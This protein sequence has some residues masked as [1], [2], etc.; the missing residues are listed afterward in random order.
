MERLII[1]V[2]GSPA[3]NAFWES[4][5][6]CRA[7]VGGIGAGKT[8]AL[9]VDILRQPA[10]SRGMIV[11]PT[12]PMLRDSTLA[13][14]RDKLWSAVREWSESDYEMTLWNG[15]KVL[16]RSADDPERLRGPNLGWAAMD[17]AALQPNRLAFDIL[18][19]RLREPPGRISLAT[20]PRGYNWIWQ[21]FIKNKLPG[22]ELFTARTRDNPHLPLEYIE[23]LEQAYMGF[24]ARQELEGQFVEWA[25]SP[26]YP[27]FSRAKNVRNGLAKLYRREAP[28]IVACDFNVRYMCWPIAQVYRGVPIVIAEIV[29][30]RPAQ[31]EQM[32]RMFRDLFPA[33]PGGVWVY[34]D[35]SGKAEST[36]S[37]QSDYDI[38]MSEMRTYPS[39]VQLRVPL[40]NPSPKDRINAVN[41]LM[42]G[43]DG[44]ARLLIDEG[45]EE[46]IIDITQTEWDKSGR[47]EKQYSDE[48]DPRS[49]RT[50]ATSALGYWLYREWPVVHETYA[51]RNEVPEPQPRLR[52]PIPGDLHYVRRSR[53]RGA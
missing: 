46:L 7:Y 29:R 26:C 48:R 36:K 31:T 52:G 47:S 1:E 3:Q 17:E 13:L 21:I 27:S 24:W 51:S 53:R 19:G 32:V 4:N 42:S 16:W 45:C 22:Y 5:A 50:H 14:F 33:H 18:L 43:I 10:G 44:G 15:T 35:A 8:W 28:L 23:T 2:Q 39:E 12:Y 40:S 38:I 20:T 11:A 9:D 30:R 34:G 25:E 41:R 49:E 6:R 37:Q